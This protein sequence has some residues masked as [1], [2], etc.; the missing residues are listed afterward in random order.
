VEFDVVMKKEFKPGAEEYIKSFQ[1]IY[2]MND[3]SLVEFYKD[4]DMLFVKRNG[5]IIEGIGYKGNNTFWT[6]E[7]DA[8][9]EL[10]KEGGVK[11]KVID[12]SIIS[13][14]K[15]RFMEGVKTF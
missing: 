1:V 14:Q 7:F 2:E 15:K 11:V 5:Q 13:D 6:S 4:G 10:Q 12:Y 9:F 8:I 3:K